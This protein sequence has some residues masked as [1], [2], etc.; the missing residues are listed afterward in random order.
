MRMGYMGMYLTTKVMCFYDFQI[1][2]GFVTATNAKYEIYI[3]IYIM[4]I[5]SVT[6]SIRLVEIKEFNHTN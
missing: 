3:Y 1:S 2:N 5:S 6:K 4:I